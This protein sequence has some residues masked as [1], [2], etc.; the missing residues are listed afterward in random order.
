[1]LDIL[2]PT[3]PLKDFL[4][5]AEEVVEGEAEAEVEEEVEEEVAEV[6]IIMVICLTDITLNKKILRTYQLSPKY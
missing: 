5:V 3:L 2:T 1:M 6:N 4:K